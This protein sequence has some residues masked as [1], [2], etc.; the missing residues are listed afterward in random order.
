MKVLIVNGSPHK[1]GGTSLAL[2]EIEKILWSH[3]IATET[4]S[5]G[6]QP[7]AGCMG[8][9]WC[10][11]NGRCVK[12]DLVNEIL[13]KSKD[14][15]GFVFGTPV[16]FASS[17][18]NLTCLMDRLFYCFG[19]SGENVFRLKPV[20]CVVCTRRS[21]VTAAL[22]QM[23]KYFTNRQMLVV[24]SSYWTGIHGNAPGEAAQD[25]EGMRSVRMLGDNLAWVLKAIDI[26]KK[27]G[28]T[29][30]EEEPPARTSFIR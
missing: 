25:L 22:D 18:G 21:G 9:G 1:D 14:V 26:A 24:S 12:N 3:Q 4:I 11:E 7:I 15:D 27:Q 10:K 16:H 8:C 28:L 2:S 30:P 17:A 19:F 23:N 20:G 13:D 6:T 5:I 29:M